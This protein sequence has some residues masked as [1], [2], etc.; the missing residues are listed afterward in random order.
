MFYFATGKKPYLYL[1][2]PENVAGKVASSYND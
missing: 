1:G 2:A